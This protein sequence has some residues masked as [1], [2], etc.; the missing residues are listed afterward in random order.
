MF[1]SSGSPA[2]GAMDV[3]QGEMGTHASPYA[4]GL[5]SPQN[6]SQASSSG[7]SMP[8]TWEEE[9]AEEHLDHNDYSYH[10]D[11]DR[12]TGVSD[13]SIHTEHGEHGASPMSRHRQSHSSCVAGLARAHANAARLHDE[14]PYES[15]YAY[16]RM[17]TAKTTK[18]TKVE[19]EDPWTTIFLLT[20]QLLVTSAEVSESLATLT[21]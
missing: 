18:T 20:T 11:A 6:P 21:S 10:Q 12:D 14:P 9:Q 4:A 15:S 17:P 5:R 13:C 19:V 16:T 1:N 7:S 3:E 2:A 8:S